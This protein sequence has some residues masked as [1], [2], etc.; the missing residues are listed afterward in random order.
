M[1][2]LSFQTGASGIEYWLPSH[3]ALRAQTQLAAE[4]KLIPPAPV[5]APIGTFGSLPVDLNAGAVSVSVPLVEIKSPQ[6]TL[7]LALSYR[8]TGVRVEEMASWVGLGWSFNPGGLM[9]RTVKGLP[10]ETPNSGYFDA[11][12]VWHAADSIARAQPTS[13]TARADK[14][15]RDG[16]AANGTL[17]IEPDLYSI[18][19]AG[20]SVTMTLDSHHRPFLNPHQNW[21]VGGSASGGWEVKLADGTTYSFDAPET[22]EALGLTPGT[23]TSFHSAWHL[24]QIT[25][26]D[27]KDQI[28]LFY[29]LNNTSQQVPSSKVNR[30][31]LYQVPYSTDPGSPYYCAQ[32]P[33]FSQGE[34]SVPSSYTTQTLQEIRTATMKVV[35]NSDMNRLDVALPLDVPAPVLR[36]I[37]VT[38]L[39]ASKAARR[40]E[41]QYGYFNGGAGR[42]SRLRLDAVQEMGKPLSVRVPPHPAAESGQLRPRPLG[43]FQRRAQ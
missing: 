27:G 26:A 23:T 29:R 34:G 7:P 41:L 33:P 4:R 36:S 24:T 3:P 21:V 15:L 1:H 19:I 37:D 30:V 8:T 20:Q 42:A 32:D 25:S 5:T 18:S 10:D 16:Q 35:F 43:V 14:K 40:Y 11:W 13:S 6:L 2:D 22:T 28:S 31:K 39:T 9:T 12:P 38:G 17:D